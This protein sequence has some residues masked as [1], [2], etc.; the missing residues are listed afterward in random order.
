MPRESEMGVGHLRL[1]FGN[2]AVVLKS[3]LPTKRS[4]KVR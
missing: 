3:I 2:I 1:S 4:I